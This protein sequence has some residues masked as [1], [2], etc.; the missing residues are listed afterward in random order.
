MISC[1][2]RLVSDRIGSL[3]SLRRKS[4][5]RDPESVKNWVLWTKI[6]SLG[7]LITMYRLVYDLVY[8][9][10]KLRQRRDLIEFLT[11]VPGF[12]VKTM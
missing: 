9:F 11:Q 5:P 2:I 7:S 1:Q 3:G 4:S 6:G 12:E 10:Q 8:D